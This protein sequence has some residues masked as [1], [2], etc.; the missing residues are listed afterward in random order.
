LGGEVEGEDNVSTQPDPIELVVF[1]PQTATVETWA[2]Y[3]AY[4]HIR[5]AETY[6]DDPEEPDDLAQRGMIRPDPFSEHRRY[7]ALDGDRIAGM[8]FV[9]WDKPDTPGYESN[10][11][12]ANAFGSIVTAARRRGIGT[13][14]AR[15]VLE[16]MV[17]EDKSVLT[18]WSEEDDGYAFLDWLGAEVRSTGAENRLDLREVDWGM[19]DDWVRQGRDRSPDTRLVFY[20]H[21]IPD[22]ALDDFCPMLGAL[23]NTM[24][25]DDMDHGDIVVTPEMMLEQYRFMDERG[26]SHH[27]YVTYELDGSISGMTDVNYEPV[28]PDRIYQRF[29]GVR[30]DCRGRGLGKWIKA[31]ML[32]YIRRTYPDAR[33]V[34]TGNANSNDPMLGINKKLGFKMYR[35]GRTYQIGRDELAARLGAEG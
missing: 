2:R 32:Q 5:H 28:H 8:L 7:A 31:A 9:R 17:A 24:P 23:L 20:E 26:S 4:R 35:A 16:H 14:F 30:P 1:D 21:R 29:T 11:R 33:W 12:F 15:K 22:D 6:P 3:H 19:V 13:A 18:T 25:F 34:I 27:T 10:K